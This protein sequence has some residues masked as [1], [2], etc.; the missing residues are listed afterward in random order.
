MMDHVDIWLLTFEK[1]DILSNLQYMMHLSRHCWSLWCSWSITCRRC[2]KNIFILDLTPGFSG[3]AKTTAGWDEKHKI[4]GFGVPYT[5]E[6]MVY[7]L[8][9]LNEMDSSFPL[10][11]ITFACGD[12]QKSDKGLLWNGIYSWEG[13]YLIT[14]AMVISEKSKRTNRWVNVRKT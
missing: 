6:L 1:I 3:W 10:Q 7:S 9:S 2:S 14:I 13:L 12:L 4:L 8:F 11:I 5:R